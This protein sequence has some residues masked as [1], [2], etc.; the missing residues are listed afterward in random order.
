VAARRVD[1]VVVTAIQTVGGRYA[2]EERLGQGGMG[3]VYRARH[4]ELG[5]VFAL[6]VIAPAFA[7]DELA[8]AR[9]NQEAKL[10]SGIKHPNAVPVV[11]FGEDP[12]LGA[13]MV[14]ELVDGTPLLDVLRLP[15][16]VRRAV[17]VLGQIADVLD[18]VHRR[19]IV[20]G[21]IK[22]ENVLLVGEA[23]GPRR[24]QVV[25]LIDFG[26][27][28][29][30]G[31]TPVT[32]VH[33]TPQYLAPERAAGGMATVASD[34]YALGVLGFLLVAGELPFDGTTLEVLTAHVFQAPRAL[35][36]VR[37]QHVDSAVEELIARAMAKDPARRHPTA[38][39]FRYEVNTIMDML[40]FERRV[41]ART[42]SNPENARSSTIQ[43]LFERS[44]M[45]QAAVTPNGTICAANRAFAQLLGASDVEGLDLLDTL[46]AVHVPD[47]AGA[48]RWVQRH[49]RATELRAHIDS[50]VPF[51]L[52]VWVAPF[53][54]DIVHVLVRVEKD[55]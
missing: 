46:L 42:T 49:R 20:H 51:D 48:L 50:D 41:R 4:L 17:N 37:G 12:V 25:R 54:P 14:M 24:R 55:V 47:V 13:Y 40:A 28:S 38:A 5:K 18:H 53:S 31:V 21:D 45:P 52:V 10:A 43:L 11:D 19:D 26:L 30:R 34:I 9:F 44:T 27:A 35:A 16:S 7:G 23:D 1:H 22:A 3:Q 15:C 29:W 32:G 33:G 39:A 8:R 6:K 2:L 36:E